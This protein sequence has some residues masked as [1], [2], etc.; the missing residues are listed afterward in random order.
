LVSGV[1]GTGSVMGSAFFSG[2]DFTSFDP[3]NQ[4]IYLSNTEVGFI[5]GNGYVSTIESFAGG[6]APN[7]F[8]T[9][10][11]QD[12]YYLPLTTTPTTPTAYDPAAFTFG[13]SS[14]YSTARAVSD[15]SDSRG[16]PDAGPI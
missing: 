3:I 12:L 13:S 5:Y 7:Y 4:P 15:P 2:I 1:G 14:I 8:G 10:T 6:T 16:F 9:S 11:F